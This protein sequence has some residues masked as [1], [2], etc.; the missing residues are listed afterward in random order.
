M[1]VFIHPL[2]PPASHRAGL[3]ERIAGGSLRDE[4]GP[5]A[6]SQ[7][8]CQSHPSSYQPTPTKQPLSPSPFTHHTPHRHSHI[9]TAPNQSRPRYA[10]SWRKCTQFKENTIFTSLYYHLP[11]HQVNLG[12]KQRSSSQ[13][14]SNSKGVFP[15]HQGSARLF[16]SKTRIQ[17]RNR[18][19]S[20]LETK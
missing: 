4:L 14:R 5:D 17:K 13:K 3:T 12:S 20:E 8:H 15:S 16:L 2:C 19:K 18:N 10:Q 9:V 11:S 1:C 7:A 6:V